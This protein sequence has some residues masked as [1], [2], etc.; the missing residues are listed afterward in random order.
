MT[1]FTVRTLND[2]DRPGIDDPFD[3]TDVND[4]NLSL[5][6]A[7]RLAGNTNFSSEDTITFGAD[8]AGGTLTLTKGQIDIRMP[9]LAKALTID[10]DINDDHLPD[11][12]I[13]AHGQS[14]VIKGG[15][16]S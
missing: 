16:A 14:R 7:L 8:L 13:D 4:P 6:E 5:R 11:I 15:S 12:T 9:I 2:E 10:G 1:T 3:D